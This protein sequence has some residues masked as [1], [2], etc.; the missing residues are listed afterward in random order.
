MIQYNPDLIAAIRDRFA[1]VDSCPFQGER[2]FFENAGGALTLKSVFETSGFYAAIPDNPGR[3]NPAGQGTQNV[4]NKAKADLA[5]FM[6]ATSG[7]FFAGESGT[8]LLFRLLRTA[9]VNAPKGSKVIGSSIEHP[10][11][12]SAARRWAGIAGLDYVNVPHD[13]ATGLV[14]AEDYLKHLT[15]DVSVAT[16][17]HASPVTGMGMD[18]A[19]I[20]RAI[21]SVAPDCFIIVDGIQHAAHGQ[22]DLAAYDVD[23]YVISPYKVFSRHGYGIAW[24]SDR[25]GAAPH[26]KLIDA[27]ATGWE[28]GT[29]DAGSYATVSDVVAYF[30]WL[31]GEVSEESEPRKRIEAAGRAIHAYETHLTNTAINGTGNLPGLRDMEHVTILAGADNAARE[32]LV[33]I[34]VDGHASEDVVERLNQQGIRTHTRKADHY[35]GNVLTP[36]GL[37][38][39]IRISFC[40]YNTEQEIARMLAAVKELGKDG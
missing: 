5:V 1:H 2:I 17:L 18:V 40:H 8:E 3:I 36:L 11:T 9:C 31:G 34:V 28:F 16:I 10:A 37:P 13:D 19:A 22:L 23:G 27:P 32:G 7:Q 6:N 21:R 33:S 38:D 4:I 15:P 39:C 29:R 35:S 14:S 30:D 25:L 26:D 20:S 12:R 24:I